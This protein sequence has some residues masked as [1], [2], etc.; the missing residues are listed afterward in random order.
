MQDTVT[1]SRQRESLRMIVSSGD[2]LLSVVND[3]LDFARLES[4]TVDVDLKEVRLQHVLDP[5]LWSMEE[6]GHA[7][8]LALRTH[9]DVELP[10][11]LCTDPR[12]LQQILYNLLSNR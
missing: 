3:V 9:F 6:K 12:R 7:K 5:V 11:T 4:G 2:L 10:I 8:K 1:D